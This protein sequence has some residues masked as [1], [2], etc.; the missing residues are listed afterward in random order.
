MKRQVC[1]GFWPIAK[2]LLT[3]FHGRAEKNAIHECVIIASMVPV[4]L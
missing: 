2:Q 3:M 4:S 1:T